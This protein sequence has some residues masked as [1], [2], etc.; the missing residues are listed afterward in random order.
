MVSLVRRLG[1]TGAQC[2]VR[3]DHQ[4]VFQEILCVR[5][6][7]TCRVADFETVNQPTSVE[8]G[9]M[10]AILEIGAFSEPLP[11]RCRNLPDVSAQSLRSSR[12]PSQTPTDVALPSG[13]GRSSFPLEERCRR[14]REAIGV[15]VSEGSSVDLEWEC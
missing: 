9:N 15:C 1:L 13:S 4:P 2:H 8:I 6:A 5:R 14:S 10:V 11:L 3:V 7:A 12:R